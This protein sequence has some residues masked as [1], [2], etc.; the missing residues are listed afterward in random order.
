MKWLPHI[1]CFIF[2]AQMCRSGANVNVSI[3]RLQVLPSP[4]SNHKQSSSVKEAPDGNGVRLWKNLVDRIQDPVKGLTLTRRILA[5]GFLLP[6]HPILSLPPSRPF[7]LFSS[8]ARVSLS[9]GT[10]KISRLLIYLSTHYDSLSYLSP[11]EDFLEEEIP[12]TTLIWSLLCPQVLRNCLTGLLLRLHN[13]L[14]IESEV[15]KWFT[16]RIHFFPHHFWCNRVQKWPP[17]K[18]SRDKPKS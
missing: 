8:S 5:S 10:G 2:L 11:A 3:W 9:T 6:L 17:R 12:K 13:P 4:S 1:C 7:S 16:L 18:A 14:Y 15:R